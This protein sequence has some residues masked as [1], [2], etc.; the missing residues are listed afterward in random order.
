[1]YDDEYDDEFD[2]E[3]DRVEKAEAQ[4]GIDDRAFYDDLAKKEDDRHNAMRADIK[5]RTLILGELEQ[6]L[7]HK[8]TELHAL[9]MRIMQ[10]KDAIDLEQKKI[11]RTTVGVNDGEPS[12]RAIPIL[13][14]DIDVPD[15]DNGFS[16]ARAEA[17]IKQLEEERAVLEKAIGEMSLVVSDEARALS[18]LQHTL[19]R[20]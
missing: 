12:V 8:K 1:M 11:Y 16:V 9:E 20:M 17:T 3:S 19:L 18:Q 15:S 14:R 6:K 7:R 13:S 2:S 5:K 10:E 4:R